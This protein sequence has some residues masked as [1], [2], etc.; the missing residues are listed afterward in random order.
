MESHHKYEDIGVVASFFYIVVNF[1]F[2]FKA[3]PGLLDVA[4]DDFKPGNHSN[5]FLHFLHVSG[6]VY[7]EHWVVDYN[8]GSVDH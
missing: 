3:P 1:L 7:S 6:R 8:L 4:V 2:V 5:D